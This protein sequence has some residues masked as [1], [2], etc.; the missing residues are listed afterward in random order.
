M[1]GIMDAI[2]RF[3]LR[4]MA[5]TSAYVLGFIVVFACITTTFLMANEF[6]FFAITG[7]DHGLE[8]FL[9]TVVV[10]FVLIAITVFPFLMVKLYLSSFGRVA[11]RVST[12][13]VIS[14]MLV[15]HLLVGSTYELLPI[16][17]VLPCTIYGIKLFHWNSTK[18]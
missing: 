10:G 13:I 7:S 16:L 17:I 6:A 11:V 5:Y 4:M 18:K 8:T 15:I 14:G 1:E 3:V 12:A 9:S 2:G